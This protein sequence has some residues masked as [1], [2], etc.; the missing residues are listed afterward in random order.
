MVSEVVVR[1]CKRRFVVSDLKYGWSRS[2]LSRRL[3][4]RF[5]IEASSFFVE[6]DLKSRD[7]GR[8]IVVLR[9]G[10]VVGVRVRNCSWSSFAVR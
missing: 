9:V 10:S 8:R 1:G 3:L 4:I 7:F 6:S 5:S 2:V